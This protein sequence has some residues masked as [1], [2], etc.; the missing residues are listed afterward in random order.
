MALAFEDICQRFE[1]FLSKKRQ[2]GNQQRGMLVLDNTTHETSLRN[3][4]REFRKTGTRRG[5]IRN[6]ADTPFFVDSKASRLVQIADHVA[7]AGF[8]RYNA[9]DAQYMDIVAHRFNEENG[10]IH[11]LCH[12]R[13]NERLCTCPACLNRRL[14]RAAQDPPPR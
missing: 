7:Y 1:T 11:G 3:L 14:S 10:V 8:R 2:G 6:I 12:K 4:S 13:N 5:N 9:G